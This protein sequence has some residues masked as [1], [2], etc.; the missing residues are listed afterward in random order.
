MEITS[1]RNKN[2]PLPKKPKKGWAKMKAHYERMERAR[3][4]KCGPVV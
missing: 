3:L 4:K 1:Q 2:Q